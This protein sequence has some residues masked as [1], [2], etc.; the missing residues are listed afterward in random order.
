[1]PIG[2]MLRWNEDKGFGF[3]RPLDGDGPDLFCHKSALLDGDNSVLD[4]DEVK[5]VMEY[6]ER[7]GK[8]RAIEVERYIRSSHSPPPQRPPPPSARREGDWDCPGCGFLV[9]GTKDECPK[10]GLKKRSVS[11]VRAEKAEQR[12]KEDKDHSLP[13]LISCDKKAKDGKNGRDGKDKD[14]K[15]GRGDR[16]EKDGKEERN[17]SRGEEADAPAALR[18]EGKT[19]I[20]GDVPRTKDSGRETND[21]VLVDKSGQM[22][23]LSQGNGST[24][25]RRAMGNSSTRMVMS[26]LDSGGRVLRK[27]MVSMYINMV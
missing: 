7:K 23:L 15:D 16:K 11:R 12:Q 5:F 22:V 19:V 24:I 13:V 6:D 1:M 3:I 17:H 27:V 20:G 2:V 9:F 18:D 10:C 26:L 8:D 25:T 14:G 4:G 21:M